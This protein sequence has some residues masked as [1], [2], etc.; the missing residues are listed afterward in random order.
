M[1]F[2]LTGAT[3][4][5][6]PGGGSYTSAQSVTIST[7]TSGASIRYTTD[8]S[9]PSETAGTLYSGPVTIGSTTTLKAIAYE[10]GMADSAVASATYSFGSGP[11]A[12]AATS[13][14]GDDGGGHTVAATIDGDFSTYWQFTA[15][16]AWVQYDLGAN[17]T[18]SSVKIAWYLGNTR[19]TRFDVRT[20][21]DGINWTTVMSGASSGT[22]TAFE[23][24]G[25][26]AVTA[27]YVQYECYGTSIDRTNAIAETQIIGQ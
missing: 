3:P 27:R 18:V 26:T 14:N 19:S 25:F 17:H 5:F 2:G 6:S 4:T 15:H 24:Y 1:E 16:Y 8:G 23:T 9:T 11:L 7:T 22:T 20:S 12:I 13:E 21:T 10:S